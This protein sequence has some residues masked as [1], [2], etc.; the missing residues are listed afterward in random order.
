[1]V[2]EWKP[3]DVSIV[4]RLIVAPFLF[5]DIQIV[6]LSSATRRCVVPC[7]WLD[8][9]SWYDAAY[10][11]DAKWTNFDKSSAHRKLLLTMFMSLRT[12]PRL[13]VESVPS[14]TKSVITKLLFI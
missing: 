5:V 2:F 14:Y 10:K 3:A 7:F 11:Q 12:E 9:S 6:F 8:T 13:E 1:M 4:R